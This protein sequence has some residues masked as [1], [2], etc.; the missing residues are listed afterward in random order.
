MVVDS[1]RVRDSGSRSWIFRYR[2]R[3]SG[4]LRDIGLGSAGR[5]GVSLEDARE[6]VA[7]LRAGVRRGLD[8][9]KAKQTPETKAL[10]GEFA[11]ALL[12]TIKSGFKNPSSERDW[13]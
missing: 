13:K 2:Q 7:E 9:L 1:L 5:D 12:E 6:R 8:P 3:G 11:D 10:F 4:K